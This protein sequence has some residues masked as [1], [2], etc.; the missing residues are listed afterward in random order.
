MKSL[1]I[2]S[3]ALFIFA[4]CNSSQEIV[5]PQDIKTASNN[6][7]SSCTVTNGWSIPTNDV[8]GNTSINRGVPEINNPQFS[9]IEE[10]DNLLLDN[11]LVVIAKV[12]DAVKIYPQRILDYHEVVNDWLDG[13]PI[14]LTFCPLSATAMCWERTIDNE[15]VEFAASGLLFNANLITY[16]NKTSSRWSQILGQSVNGSE[17]CQKLD[18]ITVL[19]TNWGMASAL[20]PQ[21]KVL[22]TVTGFSFNYGQSPI[23]FN[24]P[25]E[26]NPV[27]VASKEDP[28]VPNF[29]RVHVV[30]VDG[31]QRAYRFAE[32]A[33]G[34]TLVTDRIGSTDYMVLGDRQAQY[35]VSFKR[36]PD[37]DYQLM[38]DGRNEKIISDSKGNIINFFGEIIDGPDV[39]QKLTS[40]QS[41]TGY[42][43]SVSAFTGKL[44]IYSG[45]ELGG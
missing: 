12:G 13:T 5:E 21:A 14:A 17:I 22:N 16:D 29:E 20:F 30:E 8:L 9:S 42:W 43:Y 32:F 15:V 31:K 10:M 3:L 19:D 36:M 23:S 45:S 39:G 6:I 40:L 11:E 1:K 28:R 4:A 34:P 26:G 33:N 24:Q 27:I 7:F 35:F 37:V 18:F 44:E 25:I 2:L 38:G 41:Y